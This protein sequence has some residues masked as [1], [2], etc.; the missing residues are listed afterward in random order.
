MAP[1]YMTVE[2]T[3]TKAVRREAENGKKKI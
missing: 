1:V 2:K 3:G